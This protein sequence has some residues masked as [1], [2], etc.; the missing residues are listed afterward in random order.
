MKSSALPLFT[1]DVCMLLVEPKQ[2]EILLTIS[3]ADSFQ[4]VMNLFN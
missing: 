3:V 4:F 2:R 1:T